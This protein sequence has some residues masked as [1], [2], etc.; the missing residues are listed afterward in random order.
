M[1]NNHIKNSS[2][3]KLD[4]KHIVRVVR[5]VVLYHISPDFLVTPISSLAALLDNLGYSDALLWCLLL[6]DAE[7]SHGSK[8]NKQVMSKFHEYLGSF[9]LLNLLQVTS[10]TYCSKNMY[11]SSPYT[12]GDSQPIH[13][14]S[15]VCI[16]SPH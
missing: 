11:L 4:K 8:Q 6:I 1:M 5:C 15:S 14:F 7:R 10:R 3:S 13:I 16:S 2:D 12:Q 9:Q